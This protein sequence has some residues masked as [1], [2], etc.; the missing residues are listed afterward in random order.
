MGPG[1][2]PGERVEK[3]SMATLQMKLKTLIPLQAN[4][5]AIISRVEAP[6]QLKGVLKTHPRLSIL[7]RQ[8]AK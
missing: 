6:K 5:V 7:W 1:S 2:R 3:C 8:L 4:T